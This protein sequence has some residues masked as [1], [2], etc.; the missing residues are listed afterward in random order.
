MTDLEPEWDTSTGRTPGPLMRALYAGLPGVR[1]VRDQVDPYA[2][3]WREHSMRAVREP[4]RR[5]IVLGD[6]MS[7]GIGA[8]SYDAGWVGQLATR[9]ELD[10]QPLRVVNLSATGARVPDVVERQLPAM[11]SLPD[12]DP[13]AGATLV[14]VMVGS[15]D[16]FGGRSAR[17]LLP[18][19]MAELVD[20]LPGGAVVTTLPQP[21]R[22]AVLANRPIE[23]AGTAGTIRVAD[24]R[25]TGPTSWR[26]RLAEDWFHPNDDGYAALADAL[27]AD[28][29]TAI[30]N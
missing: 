4:G 2:E 5:W 21:S 26:G 11:A 20:R 23:M 7:Q 13:D 15:N 24:L 12:A 25:V 14:T 27:E 29:R 22:V 3:A 8:T 16:L 28:V 30:G 9:L 19:A 17:A 1:R 10:G 6:S 18:G